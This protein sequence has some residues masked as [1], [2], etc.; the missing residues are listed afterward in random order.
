MQSTGRTIRRSS[1]NVN[2]RTRC[3]NLFRRVNVV[4]P[5]QSYPR[6]AFS[7]KVFTGVKDTGPPVNFFFSLFRSF[8]VKVGNTSITRTLTNRYILCAISMA[9]PCPMVPSPTCK[10]PLPSMLVHRAISSCSIIHFCLLHFYKYCSSLR[11][12]F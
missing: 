7:C 12:V 11:L 5:M 8:W 4:R 2:R 9:N 1:I 3:R 6:R 10:E